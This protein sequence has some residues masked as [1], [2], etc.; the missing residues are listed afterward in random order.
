[1]NQ[2]ENKVGDAK[3]CFLQRR[4][5]NSEI[6][7]CRVTD[8]KLFSMPGNKTA[9]GNKTGTYKFDEYVACKKKQKKNSMA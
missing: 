3:V 8:G 6:E 1:L 4:A 7:K 2:I 9:R 5:E